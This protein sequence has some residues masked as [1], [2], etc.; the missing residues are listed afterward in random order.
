MTRIIQES[1]E[2]GESEESDESEE[3]RESEESGEKLTAQR[4]CGLVGLLGLVL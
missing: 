4:G 1:G 2:S 3:S